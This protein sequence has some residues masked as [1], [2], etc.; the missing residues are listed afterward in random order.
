MSV[1]INSL[2]FENVK[3][4][5]A[6]QLE[7]AKNGLTVIGGKN[8]QGKTSVLDAIA[9]AL[10][11][12]KYKPSSPQREGSVVEPHLKITLD[13]GIVVERSGTHTCRGMRNIMPDSCSA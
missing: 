7:P 12:D 5:K 3:K 1:K 11:G 10:G 2:E 6:V 8:R 4:I 9:W 13:N